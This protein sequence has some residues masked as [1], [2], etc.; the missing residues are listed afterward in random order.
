MSQPISVLVVDNEPGFADLAAEMLE[1]EREDIAAESATSGPDALARLDEQPIDCIVS[2]YEMPDLSGLELLERVRERDP[3]LPFILFTGRGSEDVASEAIAAGVTQY[4][5]K[6]SGSEQYALLA[7]QITNAVSRYRTETALRESERRYERTVATLHEAT[8][9]LMRAETKTDIYQQAVD[10]ASDILE[11]T[12]AVAYAF[13]PGRGVLE[14]A[15]SA[16]TSREPVDPVESFERGDGRIWDV[17]SAGERESVS[18]D[19]DDGVTINETVSRRE[20]LVPL[21]AHGVIA[22]GTSSTDGFD[23][24]TTELFQ[25]LAANTEAALDRAEREQL[26]REHDRTLTDQNEELTRLNHINEIVREINHGIAQASTREEIETTVCNRLADTDRY[27][28]AWIATTD[29]DASGPDTWDG[30]DA[31][32][33]DRIRNDD[34]APETT[35]AERTLERGC[36]QIVENVLEAD[37]WDRRRTEALTYGFQTIVAVPLSAQDHQFGVL[38]V[39]VDGVDAIGDSGRDVFA[40]LGETIGYAIRSVERT[41]AMLTDSH[42]EL[43]LVCRDER[44]LLNRLAEFVDGEITVEGVVDR[45]GDPS[46]FVSTPVTA[47]LSALADER[48]TVEATT[49]VSS[50]EDERLFELTLTSMPLWSVLRSHN[51]RLRTA[52]AVDGAAT[53]VLDVPQPTETRSLVEAIKAEFPATE[54]VARRETERTRSA[55]QLDTYLEERLTDKQ[56]AALQAAHYGGFFEWPRESTGED[57]ADALD[58]SAPTY[59]YHLRAAERKLVSLVFE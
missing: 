43:E 23:E 32:Y 20:L 46:V 55:H 28:F 18:H 47:D 38:F 36:V 15:A 11:A 26:L 29:D 10:V 25:V 40:E 12:V 37:G 34:R 58:I 14:H 56:F 59:H 17:F 19:A 3:E 44:L 33:V 5:Q 52:T 9:R 39:H 50:G 7:N 8:R 51:V 27:R 13:D 42:L 4:L 31:S 45:D 6:E 24:T 53:L 54:L 41:Q 22:A 21:G 57:L 48:A 2:D 1:R 30:I 16:R 35:L 49:L